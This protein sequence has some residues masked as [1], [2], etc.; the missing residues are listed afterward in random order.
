MIS[1]EKRALIGE[2]EVKLYGKDGLLKAYRKSKNITVTKGFQAVCDMM[3]HN[4]N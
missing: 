1:L 4:G 2:V 3:E